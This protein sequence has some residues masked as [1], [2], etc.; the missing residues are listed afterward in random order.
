MSLEARCVHC[1]KTRVETTLH[2]C[3]VC[4]KYYCDEDAYRAAGRA[5][6]SRPCSDYFFFGGE[7]EDF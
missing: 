6:C 5:F 4:H 1:G 3:S 2:K 7:E